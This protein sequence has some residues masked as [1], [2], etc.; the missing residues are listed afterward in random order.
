MSTPTS[1]PP[2]TSKFHKWHR[3]ILTICFIIFA[4]ELGF[5]LVA[6]PW[7][8]NWD[9]SYVPMHF[10]KLADIWE[11]YYFRGVLSGLGFLNI[12]VALA[13][14]KRLIQIWLSK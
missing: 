7:L 4:G 2:T 14:V 6:L 9:T 12:Y 3:V 13:E 5:V 1:A 8:S 11:N 10:P